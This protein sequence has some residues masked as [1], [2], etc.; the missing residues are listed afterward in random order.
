[1]GLGL[2]DPRFSSSHSPNSFYPLYVM[3]LSVQRISYKPGEGPQSGR[4]VGSERK[5]WRSI[6]GQ[7][8]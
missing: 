4:Q 8:S 3:R 2:A 7:P 5:G 6:P 1:M